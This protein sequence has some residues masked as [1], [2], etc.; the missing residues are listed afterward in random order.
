MVAEP[1][2][3]KSGLDHGALVLT[4]FDSLVVILPLC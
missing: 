2:R 1:G 3:V 4:T